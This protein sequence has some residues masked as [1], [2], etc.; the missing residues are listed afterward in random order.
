MDKEMIAFGSGNVF[1][2]LGIA[3][4]EE[5][6]AK[7][8]LVSKIASVIETRGL[9]QVEASRIMGIPQPK[10]SL[11][12]RGR[13]DDFSTD[14]LCRILNKLGVTVSMLLTEEPD[15]RAGVTTVLERDDLSSDDLAYSDENE[16]KSAAFSR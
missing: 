13:F 4:P 1:E 6:L 3:N 16:Q 11:L 2:D 7:A 9:T 10:V 12:V 8:D 14:R 15:W 5:H